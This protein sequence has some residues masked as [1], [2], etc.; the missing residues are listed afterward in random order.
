MRAGFGQ[1]S[2]PVPGVFALLRPVRRDRRVAE[3]RQ[4]ARRGAGRWQLHDLVKLR[5]TVEQYGLSLSAPRERAHL[6]L[7]PHHARRPQARRA[8]REHDRH[9]AQHRPCGHPHIRLPTG[10][11]QWYG[12]P[13]PPTSAAAPSQPPSNYDEAREMPLTHDR[14]YTEEEMWKNLEHW[15]RI[16]TPHRRGGGHTTGHPPPATRRCPSWAASRSCSAASTPTNGSSRYA[17]QTRTA[18]SSARA[19]SPEMEG[20]DIYEMIRYFGRA[21]EDP[22][23]PLPQ[24]VGAGAEVPR[25][26]HQTPATWTCTGP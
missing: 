16:I 9:R 10:C 13:R 5:L 1:F 21:P 4:P 22:L 15:I 23:R 25:G 8:D 11:R 7:R 24:R 26:V 20:E 17:R 2:Q 3:Q 14:E 19:R 6:V 18:S 12:A